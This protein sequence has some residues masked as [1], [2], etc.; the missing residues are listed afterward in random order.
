VTCA[1]QTDCVASAGS[2][3]V[4]CK[5]GAKWAKASDNSCAAYT[6]TNCATKSATA[7]ECTSCAS[8]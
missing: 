6:K 2:K 5:G 8:G 1:T 7:D 3:C 4:K